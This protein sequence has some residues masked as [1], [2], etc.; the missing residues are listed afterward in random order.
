VRLHTKER[1]VELT[2]NG[3]LALG[4]VVAMLLKR[5]EQLEDEGAKMREQIRGITVEWLEERD[6][7]GRLE[8]RLASLEQRFESLKSSRDE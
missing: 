2:E 3:T 6:S 5:I 4:P 7:E 8:N 1:E